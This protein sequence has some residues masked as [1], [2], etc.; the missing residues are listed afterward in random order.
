M[1]ET[2][3]LLSELILRV[4][5]GQFAIDFLPPLMDFL[6]HIIRHSI[7]RGRYLRNVAHWGFESLRERRKRPLIGFPPKCKKGP[8]LP[9]VHLQLETLLPRTYPIIGLYHCE[10]LWP[11][12]PCYNR[13]RA[14]IRRSTIISLLRVLAQCAEHY[15]PI[16]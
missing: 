1:N 13:R 3:T 14:K 8:G 11:G 4:G 2:C 16:T 6:A 7:P 5:A 15:L 10:S 12:R 9:S